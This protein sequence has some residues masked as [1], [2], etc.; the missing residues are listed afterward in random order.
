MFGPELVGLI[1]LSFWLQP[2]V[3]L[4]VVASLFAGLRATRAARGMHRAGIAARAAQASVDTF[5]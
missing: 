3:L 5:E 2:L 4:F 1:S